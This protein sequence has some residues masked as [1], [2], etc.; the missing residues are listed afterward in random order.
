[1]PLRNLSVGSSG[2]DVRAIQNALNIQ[3]GLPGAP[4]VVDG[5]FGRLSDARVRAYQTAKKLTVDGIVGRATR[6]ALAPFGVATITIVATRGS[7][8][9]PDQTTKTL[10][11][12]WSRAMQGL[13][14]NPRT[15]LNVDWG[16]AMQGLNPNPQ[17]TLNVDWS[18]VLAALRTRMAGAHFEM[19]R[20]P[21]IAPP[22][23]AGRKPEMTAPMPSPDGGV[24]GFEY[25][26]MELV[27]GAQS[28]FFIGGARQDIFTLTMQMIYRRGPDDAALGAHQEAAI[29][30]Q[31]GDPFVADFPNGAP[32]TFNPFIQL[33]DVDRIGGQGIF[34]PWQPYVS[35]GVQFQGP[36]APHWTATGS[37][38]PFNLGIDAGK[39]LT[40]TVA[41][42][43]AMNYDM[44]TGKVT[45][46]PQVIGGLN[47]KF[48]KAK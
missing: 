47:I 30:V 1:M 17:T 23:Y 48:G 45:A 42:G 31:I 2:E 41:G 26:H 18:A 22:I 15:T 13:N 20:L 46:G 36:G 11:V 25:D 10:N 19:T 5:V 6:L 27:P 14:P 29:G 28:T 12:D 9:P 16:R 7:V 35:M 3:R 34:H 40:F 4:L 43:F 37:A 32:W 39:Y 21:G 38:F 33:T 44:T 8:K 24:L